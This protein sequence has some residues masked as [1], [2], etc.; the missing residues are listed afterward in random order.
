[1]TEKASLSATPTRSPSDKRLIQAAVA[2]ADQMLAEHDETARRVKT[3]LKKCG[4]GK[5]KS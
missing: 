3:A 5:K 1:M 4:S 2:R